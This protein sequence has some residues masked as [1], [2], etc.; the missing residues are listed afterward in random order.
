MAVLNGTTDHLQPWEGRCQVLSLDGGGLRG[1]FSAAVL[2]A[3]EQDLDSPVLDHFD[4]VTG[5]STGGLIALALGAGVPARSILEFFV[6]EGPRVFQAPRL[7]AIRHLVR[8][9]YNGRALDSALHRL[10]GEK[11]LG[12]SC[13]RLVIP[14]FDMTRN[15]VYLLKTPH[16]PRLRRDWRVPM[17]EAARSTAAA[18]TYLPA[19]VLTEDRTVLVDGGVWANNPSLVGAVEATSLLGASLS[20]VRL[21]NIG[22]TNEFRGLPRSLARGGAFQWLRGSALIDVLMTSQATGAFTAAQHLLGADNVERINPSVPPRLLRLDRLRVDDAI[23]WAAGE[24][25]HAAP[26]V[27]ERFYDHVSV[28]YQAPTMPKEA[29]NA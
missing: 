8:S 14:A 6:D 15:D 4:L 19:H 17:W 21:L 11:L 16:H 18:P 27:Q 28:P 25:R 9:K 12:E 7:R 5:T 10:F 3:L 22:T 23:A 1:I 20:N 13:V 24:S 26:R 29:S 2:A